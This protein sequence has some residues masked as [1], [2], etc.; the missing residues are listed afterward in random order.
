M[1]SV[2]IFCRNIISTG[3]AFGIRTDTGEQ[4]FIPS[5]VVKASKIQ[6][7]ET[8]SATIAPNIHPNE[9]TPWFVIRVNRD[10]PQKPQKPQH[11]HVAYDAA[12]EPEALAKTIDER[13]LKIVKDAHGH[14]GYM[15]TAEVA[16]ELKA[17]STIA[18]NA[19]L[20]LFNQGKI[21]KADVYGS[22][23]QSRPSFCLW[24]ASAQTFIGDQE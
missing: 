24:A 4:A 20:R 3:S 2:E 23:G 13:A 10:Q 17:D 18:H 14:L 21:S 5:S 12:R 1:E 15:T 9:A 6:E 16:E 22:G 11:E 19:L 8:A 7:G